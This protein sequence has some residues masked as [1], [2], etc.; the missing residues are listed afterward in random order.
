PTHEV[1]VGLR[2]QKNEWQEAFVAYE[3]DSDD[4]W[5][6]G[7]HTDTKTEGGQLKQANPRTTVTR[8]EDSQAEFG[9]GTLVGTKATVFGLELDT[10][11]LTPPTFTRPSVAYLS[12]GMQ[13]AQDVPRFEQAVYN[14]GLRVEEGTSNLFVNPSFE[15]D[16]N[17]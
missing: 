5:N 8:T 16:S 4:D 14:Q 12:D 6:S 10:S 9:Q 13:V 17:G 15:V 2:R 11:N 1:V 3:F 7:T